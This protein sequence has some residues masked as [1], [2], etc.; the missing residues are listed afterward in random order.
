MTLNIDE[1]IVIP[2]N[3]ELKI[4]EK[5]MLGEMYLSFSYGDSADSYKPGEMVEGNPPKA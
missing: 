3:S 2:K 5:G 4:A 1:G